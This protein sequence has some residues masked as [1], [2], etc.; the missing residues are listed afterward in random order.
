MA[1]PCKVEPI[2][3]EHSLDQLFCSENTEIRIQW[4]NL[5]RFQILGVHLKSG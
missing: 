4:V 2:Y 3:I 5:Q 1:T